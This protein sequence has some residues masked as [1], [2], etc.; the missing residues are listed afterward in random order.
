LPGGFPQAGRQL[1]SGII[2]RDWIDIHNIAGIITIFLVLVHLILHGKWMLQ[3]TKSLFRRE[4]TTIKRELIKRGI[5]EN[6]KNLWFWLPY[7]SQVE[8]IGRKYC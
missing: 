7:L 1:F 5:Y 3:T 8:D 2:R 4:K 6:N